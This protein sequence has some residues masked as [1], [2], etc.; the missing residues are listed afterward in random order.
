MRARAVTAMEPRMVPRMVCG[1]RNFQNACWNASNRAAAEE[2]PAASP[3][4]EAAPPASA[5]EA[6][7]ATVTGLQLCPRLLCDLD[8]ACACSAIIT[9]LR[10]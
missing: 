6:A 9:M 10:P 1:R 3:P 8:A 7:D 2:P 5:A 4:M